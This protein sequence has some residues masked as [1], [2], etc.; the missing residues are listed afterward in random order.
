MSISSYSWCQALA[1]TRDVV[2]PELLILP[3]SMKG[4]FHNACAIFV[5]IFF[6]KGHAADPYLK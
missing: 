6:I 3:F 1:A 2:L 5:L 4:V